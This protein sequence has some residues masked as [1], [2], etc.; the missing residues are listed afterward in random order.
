MYMPM[1]LLPTLTSPAQLRNFEISELETLAAEIRQTICTQVSHSGGHL[2][3]NLGV[4]ELT[5]ALHYVFD[6]TH[7]RL[8]FD[9]GHQCYPHKLLTGRL[10][11][12]DRLRTSEGL[13][14][15]PAPSESPY[16]LFAVGHAGTGIS[17]A[18]G[19]ARGDT[20]RGEAYDPAT[21]PDGR[22]VVTL[23]GDASI[24]NGV[25]LEGL[26]KA[27]TLKRQFR[28]VLHANGMS[29]SKPQGAVSQY[30]DRLRMSPIYAD[31]K[32]GAK[33]ILS[34]MPGGSTLGDAYH[35][36]GEATKAMINEGAWFEHFG[37]VT[38]GPIDGHSLPALIEFLTEAKD[39]D[40]PMV[41]HVQT[42]KGK[43]FAFSENDASTFHSPPTFDI[44]QNENSQACQ[45]HIKSKARSFTTAFGESMLDIMATDDRIVAATDR[46]STRR[47]PVTL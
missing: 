1:R 15:F 2:A 28:T 34:R 38:I 29:I 9:V 11:R 25:A 6:F 17:T 13:S 26:N 44:V 24:V 31:L 45:V 23:I 37:L 21:N 19:M 46:K 47:T 42:T 22:R 41:L 30:F 20:L 14:G 16:D 39:F 36:M 27:G 8:L 33:G 3:P 10:D 40:R 12:F 4:V 7:D 35:K 32:R 18:V 5:I 43:G